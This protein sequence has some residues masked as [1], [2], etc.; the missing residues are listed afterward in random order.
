M[1]RR[2]ALAVLA[3]AA[4]S[5]LVALALGGGARRGRAPMNRTRAPVIFLAHGSPLLLD[6]AGWTAELATWA[7]ALPRPTAILMISAHWEARP[8]TLGATRTFPLVHDFHGFPERHYRQTYPAPGAPALAARVRQLLGAAVADEPE[9]GL[10]HGAYV[11]L[12]A[13]FPAADVPVLQLSLPTLD[14]TALFA[15]GRALAPLRDEGVLI[16]GSGFLTHNLRTMSFRP[17]A[18]PPAW[19]VELDA[20]CADVLA[21]RDVDALLDYRARGPGVRIA[22]PT[23]EHF[24]PVIV[25]AGAGIEDEVRFPITGFAYGSGAKRSVQLG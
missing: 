5:P 11:P 3:A 6:D 4:A 25:A 15:M 2:T 23:H 14:P 24:V 17:G 19:A 20:W 9:R 1:N 16:V 12:V 7:A 21:R 22:L 10:D 8:A 18:T 13:M